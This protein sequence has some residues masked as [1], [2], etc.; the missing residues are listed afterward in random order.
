MGFYLD[1]Q[2]NYYEGD[3]ADIGHQGVPQRP[4]VEHKWEGKWV[5]DQEKIYIRVAEENRIAQKMKDISDNLHSWSE[6]DDVFNK[7]STDLDNVTS[8][9]LVKPI[10]STLITITKKMAR[11]LYWLAKDKLD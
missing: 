9:A 6:V 1:S 11:V 8:L 2:G 10:V 3:K 7:L 5:P 4:S